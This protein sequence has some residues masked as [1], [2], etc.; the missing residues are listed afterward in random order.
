MNGILAVDKP[1]GW[2][3]HDIVAVCRRVARG[4][5]TGHGGT[6]DPLASGVLPV[7]F[8]SATKFVERLHTAPKVYGA[9]ISFGSETATD[10]RQG[11][12]TTTAEPPPLD[13]QE[14]D[15]RLDAFRG[16]IEQVP[17]D[18]AAVKVGGR[19]AYARA[20]AGER[21]ALAPRPVRIDRLDIASWEPP[22]LRCL[23]VCSSGTYVRSLARDLGRSLGSAAHL[24]GLIR[25]AVG[26]LELD[27]AT[28]I[29]AVRPLTA[30]TLGARLTPVDE[31]LLSLPERYRTA[32]ADRLL[33]RWEAAG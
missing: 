26:A 2:T 24:G 6:L 29:E 31:A 17:P 18:F 33:L 7:L 1:V 20:R 15:R 28:P 3:S 23:V 32:A 8:G 9:L 14:L 5:R 11:A 30:E 27:A 4:A 25:L 22:R 10:D 12:A 19:T 21:L 16:D 13:R